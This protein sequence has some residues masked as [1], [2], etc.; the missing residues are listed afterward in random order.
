M[1]LNEVSKIF[2]TLE[3]FILKPINTGVGAQAG[4]IEMQCTAL[5]CISNFPCTPL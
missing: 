2:Q 1:L 4:K 5:C 3:N